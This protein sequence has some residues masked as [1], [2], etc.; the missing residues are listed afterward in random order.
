MPLLLPALLLGA[1]IQRRTLVYL[2]HPHGADDADFVIIS[3]MLTARVRHGMDVESRRI[4]FTRKLSKA[5]SQLLLQVVVYT[6]LGTEEDYATL[7][8][9]NTKSA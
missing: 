5:L 7:G 2:L 9:W 6:I 8:D 3:P 1:W 4:R